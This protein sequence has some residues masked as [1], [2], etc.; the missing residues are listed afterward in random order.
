MG[1]LLFGNKRNCL[2]MDGGFGSVLLEPHY[3]YLLAMLS[4]KEALP[5]K[6]IYRERYDRS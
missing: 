3:L 2:F 5:D 6:V 4:L 1:I